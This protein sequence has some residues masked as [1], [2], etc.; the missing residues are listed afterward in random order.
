MLHK[1]RLSKVISYILLL[2]ASL[3]HALKLSNTLKVV[4]LCKDV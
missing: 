3:A 4:K 2:S 1:Y